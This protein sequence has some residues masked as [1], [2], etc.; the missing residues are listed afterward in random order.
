MKKMSAEERIYRAMGQLLI[1]KPLHEITVNEIIETADVSKSTFYRQFL[2]K[3]DVAC[4]LYDQMIDPLFKDFFENGRDYKNYYRK[5][6]NLIRDN[7]TMIESMLDDFY[8]QNSVYTYAINKIYNF[9]CKQIPAD[10]LTDRIRL[11]LYAFTNGMMAVEWGI[12]EGTFPMDF[13]TS[14]DYLDSMV[15]ECIRPVMQ[16]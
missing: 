11:E 16:I 6:M 9:W 8:S 2:D 15:P 4:K 10:K 5:T 13:E 14:L 1:K 7:K 3:Y 12:I